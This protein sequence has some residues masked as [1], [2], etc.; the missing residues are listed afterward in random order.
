MTVTFSPTTTGTRS[1]NITYTD[2]APDSPQTLPLSGGA[3]G[4]AAPLAITTQFFA[5]SNGICDVA[6]GSNVFVNN[7][8]SV[9]FEA[10]GGTPPYTWSG[11]V[12]AGL[13][14]RPSGLVVGDPTTLGTTTFSMTVTDAA[15]TTATGMFSLTVT[16]PPA[17]SPSGCQT[18]GVVREPLSGSAIG[19]KTPSGLATADETKLGCG[20]FALLT[21]QVKDVNLPRGTVLWVALDGKPVGTITLNGGS[22]TMAQYNMGDFGV[23]R[24]SVQVFNSLPDASP[25]QQILIGSFFSR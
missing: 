23:R 24:D 13:T 7:F 21:V 15:G 8:Y 17:P 11:Q 1:A 12:P 22:G 19:G 3:T 5:C 25:F 9:S 6:D 4:A 20:G 2:N 16:N 14:L 18:G 10:S